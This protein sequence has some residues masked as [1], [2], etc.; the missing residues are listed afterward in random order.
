MTSMVVSSTKTQ[1]LPIQLQLMFVSSTP[2]HHIRFGLD[3]NDT[4]HGGPDG[5]MIL[6]DNGQILRETYS[7]LSVF[8]WTVQEWE[9]YNAPFDH[10]IIRDVTRYDDIDGVQS[11]IYYGDDSIFGDEGN[12]ILHG[13]RGDDN[14]TGGDGDDELYGELGS[15]RLF[16]GDGTCIFFQFLS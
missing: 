10:E 6:G 7:N 12:D 8:P 3:T 16:G 1:C 14:I 13:Q 2:G 5:D 9:P 15:D 4:L 11:D